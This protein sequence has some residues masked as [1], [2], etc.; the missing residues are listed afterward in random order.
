MSE[1]NTTPEEYERLARVDGWVEKEKY[2]DGE[3]WVDAETFVKRGREITPILRENNK[4]LLKKLEERDREIAEIK[5]VAEDFKK[6]TKTASEAK[7]KDLETQ[8][9]TLREQKSAAVT[10][11]NGAAVVEID[12]AID[13]VKEQIVEAKTVKT[14]PVAPASVALDPVIVGWMEKNTWFATDT[15]YTRIADAVGAELAMNHPELKGQAFFDKLD[16]EL[17]EVL[18]AKYKK[19]TRNPVEAPT[20]GTNRPAVSGKRG[21][22]DLPKEAQDAANRYIKQGLIKTKEDYLADY[23]WD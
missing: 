7:V 19:T 6:F 1:D 9:K 23:V 18:P 4:K 16:E 5:A 22:A 11:G 3:H 21:F 15:K 2:R 14:T 8:I 13:S 10:D 12:E 17:E 20:Q